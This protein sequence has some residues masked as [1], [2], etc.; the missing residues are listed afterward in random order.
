MATGASMIVATKIGSGCDAGC[1]N[2]CGGRCGDECG[3]G[4][5]NEC[6]DD[7]GDKCSD[8]KWRSEVTPGVGADVAARVLTGTCNDGGDKCG[9]RCVIRCNGRPWQRM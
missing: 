1:G 4:L 8:G 6:G 7:G 3:D 5:G 2:G 9:D